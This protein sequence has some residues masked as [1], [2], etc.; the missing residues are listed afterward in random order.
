MGLI[1]P[2]NYHFEEMK[3]SSIA[4]ALG[5]PARNR[6]IELLLENGYIRNID[7]SSYLNL[8]QSTVTEH[9][10]FLRKA[11]L[12]RTQYHVHYDVLSIEFETLDYFTEC[13]RRWKP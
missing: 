12:I 1:K 8:S 13:L 11:E 10:N 6:I 3:F 7:L 5:H 9:L 4:K 2:N